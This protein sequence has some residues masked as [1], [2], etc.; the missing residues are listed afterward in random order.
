MTAT[1]MRQLFGEL[2]PVDEAF[3]A[4]SAGDLDRMIA[5]LALAKNGVD[6]HFL[7]V[8]IVEMAWHVRAQADRAA[9]L[10]AFAR[11]HVIE[12]PKLMPDLVSDMP[13]IAHQPAYD[14]L[15]ALLIE[16]GRLV[17]A[18]ELCE[19]AIHVSGAPTY[20]SRL[21]KINKSLSKPG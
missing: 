18:K 12:F 7:L 13:H 14:R 21:K 17:E 19:E 15:I 1:R 11:L 2:V 9:Q 8:R 10:E 4:W 6:R 20:A 16:Q 5:A 3:D